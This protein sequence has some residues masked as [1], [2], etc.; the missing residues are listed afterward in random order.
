MIRM[1]ITPELSE[2]VITSYDAAVRMRSR[3]PRR[4][5]SALQRAPLVRIIVASSA[6]IAGAI[7]VAGIQHYEAEAGELVRTAQWMDRHALEPYRA[8]RIAQRQAAEPPPAPEVPPRLAAAASQTSAP[9]V[10]VLMP[11]AGVAVD[12]VRDTW[13]HRRSGGRRH[14]GQDIFA[15]RGTAV[16]SATGGLIMQIQRNVGI[17]G[18]T[19]SVL[20]PDGRQYYYA[21][22]A[23]F[24]SGLRVGD[25]VGPHTVLGTVGTTGNA[26][27]TRP[28]LHFGIY[29]PGRGAINPL[30]L[31]IDRGDTASLAGI[32]A[33]SIR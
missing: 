25:H 12:D 28:H 27:Y 24:A 1:A 20:G 32:T 2:I 30:P 4:W 17:G 19:V 18:N 26:A 16:L 29:V 6:I 23:G 14:E 33:D 31:L 21:H 15:P 5:N 8:F 10:A 3:Q 13:G 7:G 9:R 11:V 22:L